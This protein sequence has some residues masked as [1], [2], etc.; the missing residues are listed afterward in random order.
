MK[1]STGK[2]L[3]LSEGVDASGADLTLQGTL[4]AAWFYLGKRFV[5][6]GVSGCKTFLQV[7]LLPSL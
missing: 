5:P 2:Y 6:M 7:L 3:F 4:A 1:S